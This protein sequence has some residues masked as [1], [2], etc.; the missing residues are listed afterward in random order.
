MYTAARCSPLSAKI[1]KNI[2]TITVFQKLW[3]FVSAHVQ[4]F[5]TFK[6]KLKSTH[7]SRFYYNYSLPASKLGLFPTSVIF[8]AITLL[9]SLVVLVNRLVFPLKLEHGFVEFLGSEQSSTL[10][11]DF[12]LKYLIETSFQSW[13]SSRIRQQTDQVWFKGEN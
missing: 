10:W 2:C 6:P 8:Q 12:R 13:T 4:V 3:S 9:N 1:C 5:P 7:P 11:P